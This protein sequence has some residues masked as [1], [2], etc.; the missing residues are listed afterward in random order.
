MVA[1]GDRTVNGMGHAASAYR[2]WLYR[3]GNCAQHAGTGVY[4]LSVID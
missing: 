2:F 3:L 4:G 1:V